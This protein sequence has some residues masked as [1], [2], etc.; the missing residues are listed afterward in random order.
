MSTPTSGPA[1]VNRGVSGILAVVLTAVGI[2][3]PRITQAGEAAFESPPSR[4]ALE[5]I[6]EWMV[7]GEYWTVDD[8]VTNY[9][10][11]HEFMVRSEWG[12]FEVYGEPMLRIRLKELVAIGVL[13]KQS[14]GSVAGRAALEG[15]TKAARDAVEVAKHPVKTAKAMPRGIARMFK[16]TVYDVGELV[17]DV[18]DV[19][20]EA[21][22]GDTSK[23]GKKA[24]RAAGKYG[25]RYVGIELQERI[26]AQRLG[27]D[28]YTSNSLLRQELTRV[29]AIDAGAKFATSLINPL[30][31]SGMLSTLAGVYSVV[32][33]KDHREL[34]EWI[35]LQMIELGAEPKVV[36][37]L[38]YS[39][40]LPP[41]HLSLF[42]AVLQQLNGVEARSQSGCAV[43]TRVETRQRLQLSSAVVL[44]DRFGSPGYRGKR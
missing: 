1:P 43:L 36:N 4:N 25:K 13:K 35:F 6:P 3:L 41:G 11:L 5:V 19:G 17:G 24:G 7:N 12:V 22:E 8:E 38:L 18:A 21:T 23:A 14:M 33:E 29:A 32:W 31:S 37:R 34:M 2:A 44:G 27:V 20:G 9:D 40:A 15:A 30:P 28:P 10:S 39:E 42:V 26:W 16:K